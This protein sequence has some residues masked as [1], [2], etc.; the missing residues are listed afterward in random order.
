MSLPEN[1][2]KGGEQPAV[3]SIVVPCL[4]EHKAI[5][6]TLERLLRTGSDFEIIVVDGG[7][8]D[9]TL[10]RLNHPRLRV[11]RT[12]KGRGHQLDFGARAA[13]GDML[14]FLHADTLINPEAEAALRA[15][16]LDPSITSGN[17]C[18]V[19]DGASRSARCL[20]WIYRHLR[21]IGLCYGDSGFFVRAEVYR[22]VGGFAD[23]PLFED[24]DLLRRLRRVGKFVRL[25]GSITTSSRRFED[26]FILTFAFWT[27]LQVLY[28]LGCDPRRLGKLYRV[29]R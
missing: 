23:Y 2:V 29:V 10:E 8:T 11:L 18:L 15:A 27:F 20:T 19:F 12:R 26:R 24:L 21:L 25:P 16:R 4:N 13:R 28:W 7:S 3:I 1:F 14:W 22:R 5:D 9:G 17:F 6:A